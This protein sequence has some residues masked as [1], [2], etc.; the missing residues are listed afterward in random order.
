M[1][2]PAL[3]AATT[4]PPMIDATATRITVPDAVTWSSST[5]SRGIDSAIVPA[6]PRPIDS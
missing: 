2:R 6:P 5:W 4:E 3:T 1:I